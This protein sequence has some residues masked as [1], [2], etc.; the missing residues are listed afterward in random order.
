M[1][2]RMNTKKWVEFSFF[3]DRITHISDFITTFEA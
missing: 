1:W 3:S 2:E